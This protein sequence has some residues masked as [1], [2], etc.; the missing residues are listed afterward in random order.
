MHELREIYLQATYW[1]LLYLK[2]NLDKGIMFKRNN[3][4]LVETYIN[5]DYAGSLID[6]RFTSGNCTFLEET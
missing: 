5:T 6:R 1:I 2:G 3:G 4:L